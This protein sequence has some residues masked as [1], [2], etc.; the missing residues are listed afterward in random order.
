MRRKGSKPAGSGC[1]GAEERKVAQGKAVEGG[2]GHG[3]KEAGGREASLED[4]KGLML[5]GRK[6]ER[7]QHK[8]NKQDMR[9]QEGIRQDK[10]EERREGGG[11][12]IQERGRKRETK[13]KELRRR[14]EEPR[15]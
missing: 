4:V 9:N 12:G 13:P 6:A 11:R 5:R 14:K 1:R 8:G 7:R 3:G 15:E 2:S 10:H